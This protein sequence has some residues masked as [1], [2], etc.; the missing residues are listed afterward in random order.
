LDLIFLEVSFTSGIFFSG[1]TVPSRLVNSQFI[2]QD[3]SFFPYWYPMNTKLR[4]LQ[5]I[6]REMESVVVAFSGGIDSTLLLKVAHDVLG[7]KA[8]AITA[9]SASVPADELVEAQ[10]LAHNIGANHIILHSRETQDERYLENTPNRCYFCRHITLEDIIAYA[11]DNNYQYVIDGN[12]ADDVDDYRP[13]RKAAKEHG[14]R[15]PLQEVGI[16]KAEIRQMAKELGLPNWNKPAAAC[17]SSRIPYGTLI[18]VEMLSQV[19]QAEAALKQ[20]GFG[21]LRVRH[22]DQ[23]ARI[24]IPSDDFGAILE[25][26]EAIITAL[27]AVGYNYVTLDLVG[28][29][30]GAMN[31]VLN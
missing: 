25:N 21:Q 14:V 1:L 16:A 10:E 19:D 15:S 11:Q 26:R 27:K 18:T 30:S 7:D 23:V 24:E 8:I 2:T 29:R 4:K 20:M 5:N 6:I 17:L 9:V 13:G 31:E 3:F 22:H 12:N 28:F